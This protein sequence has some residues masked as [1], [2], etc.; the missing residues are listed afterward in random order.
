M[1]VEVVVAK[2]RPFHLVSG[3]AA[4]ISVMGFSAHSASIVNFRRFF[5]LPSRSKL[6]YSKN[7][8]LN[9]CAPINLLF[10]KYLFFSNVKQ[11]FIFDFLHFIFKID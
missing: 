6:F 4:V 3:Y 10:V 2:R 8:N 1:A 7:N 9:Y 5:I 11:Q